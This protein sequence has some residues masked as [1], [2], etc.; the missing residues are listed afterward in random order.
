MACKGVVARVVRRNCHNRTRT[1]ACQHVVRN[2]DR[3]LLAREGIYGIRTRSHAAH[4]LGLG[5]T[6]TL[7]ALLGLGD[8]LLDCRT[9]LVGSQLINP[10][11]LGRNNHKRHA[12]DR[13]GAGGEDLQLL[14]HTLHCE[15]HLRTRAAT[16]PV[17]LDLFERVAPL[18]T[19]QTVQHTLCVSRNTQQPLLHSLLLNGVTATLRQTVLHLI[20]SQHRTQRRT[21]IHHRIGTE[22]QTV[23]LQHLL[24]LL[25]V[26]CCPLLSRELHLGGA[27]RIDTLGAVSRELGNQLLDRACLLLHV[28]VVV[29]EHL[30]ECPLSPFVVLGITGAHLAAPIERETDLV[31]LLT[32]AADVLR[33]GHSG[34][35]TRLDSI[36]LG[37]Q[38]KGVVTHRVQNVETAQTLV[39]R[40]DIRGDVAQR[41]TYVQTC[42]RRIGEHIEDIE[43]GARRIDLHFVGTALAPLFLPFGFDGSKIVF[44][45]LLYIF[46]VFVAYVQYIL[47]K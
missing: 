1:V 27:S 29:R 15:E 14:L 28:V 4:A 40:I 44:H 24:T 22:R 9:I 16:D 20:V 19:L 30:H 32:I 6:L 38:T 36:L 7:R 35:L 41:V 10:L 45:N 42:A 33:C 8:I 11:V 47:Q 43:F 12:K 39:A 34:V 5:N 46:V 2:I 31:Q 26:H 13:I 37:G 3:N 21:P 17:A 25:L 18:Q 23:V